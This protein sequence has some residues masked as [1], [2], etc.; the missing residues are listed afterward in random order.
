MITRRR[1]IVG[2]GT[3]GALGV[4][5]PPRGRARRARAAPGRAAGG[6]VVLRSR[7]PASSRARPAMPAVA[8]G[9]CEILDPRGLDERPRVGRQR[10]YGVVDGGNHPP[11]TTPRHHGGTI[12]ER[13]S[14]PKR[15]DAHR[16]HWLRPR[17]DPPGAELLPDEAEPAA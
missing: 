2:A 6:G 11:L 1:F 14:P 8:A 7:T 16:P 13:W 10:A 5:L 4:A 9:A 3:A 17:A 15:P 12:E